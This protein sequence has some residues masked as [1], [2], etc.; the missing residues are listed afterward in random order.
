[1]KCNLCE[2]PIT[3]YKAEFNHLVI[4]DTHSVKICSECFDKLV[5]WQGRIMADLFP[6]K[7]LKKR[8]GKV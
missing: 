2:K 6:T 1:M 7:A 5:K 4:D 3:D 8:Y